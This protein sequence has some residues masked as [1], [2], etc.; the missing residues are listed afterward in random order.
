[1]DAAAGDLFGDS[2]AVSGDTAVVGAIGDDDGGTS[3]GSAYV[4][5][6]SA[7]VWSQQQKL[8]ASDALAG[9]EFGYSVAVSGDTAVVGARS[10]SDAG[11]FSGSAYVFVRSAGVWS[12]QQ[13]LT[14]SDAAAGDFFGFSVAVSGDTA[15]VGAI[16]DDD[17]GSGSGSAYVF[18]RS[19]GVWSQQ[20]KLTASDAA[21]SDSFGASVAV[22]GDTAVV[23]ASF[24]S[25]A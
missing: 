10:D 25:D 1:S 14:A 21:A 8:T 12:Q 22:S 23:G 13:K 4:F 7:G 24:D 17:A 11:T 3:S 19:A 15:V 20:Q 18:V 9:D 6:R 2:V 16:F 5:V